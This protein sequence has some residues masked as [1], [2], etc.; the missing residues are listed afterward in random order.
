MTTTTS[1]STRLRINFDH[2]T[3]SDIFHAME[4]VIATSQFQIP[5]KFNAVVQF[6]IVKDDDDVN[7]EL[8]EVPEVPVVVASQCFD[9]RNKQRLENES[10]ANDIDIH[11]ITTIPVL[12]SL[13]NQNL[14]PQQAFLKKMLKIKG[15]MSVG[16]KLTILLDATRK[17]LLQQQQ[18]Q[19]QQEQCHS[20]ATIAKEEIRSKL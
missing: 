1:P 5:S 6:Q 10:L 3:I 9:A 14:S 4:Q 16:M 17:H 12:H 20:T 18:Q 13:L 2:V 19:Q 11:V 8:P 15:K 7:H